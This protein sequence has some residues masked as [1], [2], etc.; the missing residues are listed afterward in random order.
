MDLRT[1]FVARTGQDNAGIAVIN[2][3]VA[4]AGTH[5]A[6]LIEEIAG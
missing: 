5:N 3:R 4:V 6:Q 1:V 2:D